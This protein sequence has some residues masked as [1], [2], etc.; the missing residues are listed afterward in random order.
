M[1]E[2]ESFAIDRGIAL[3][4]NDFDRVVFSPNDQGMT[5]EYT[6]DSERFSHYGDALSGS[7]QVKAGDLS[8]S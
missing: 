2:L 7:L 3:D 4:A 6:L 1:N 8:Q 5:I